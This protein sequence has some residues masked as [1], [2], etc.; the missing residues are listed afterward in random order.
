MAMHA[1]TRRARSMVIVLVLLVAAGFAFI[2]VCADG[3]AMAAAYRTCE[4][5]GLEWQ[6]YDRTAADGARRTLCL[7]YLRSRTCYQF[8][9]GPVV[10]CPDL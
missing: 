7:G 4:C 10:A 5:R 8:R 1:L 2:Q 6:I 9:T 3:G